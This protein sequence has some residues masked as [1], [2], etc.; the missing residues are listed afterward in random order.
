M[1]GYGLFKILVNNYVFLLFRK[2]GAVCS[3]IDARDSS[4]KAPS[5]HQIPFK[6]VLW[7]R[8]CCGWHRG[9]IS[10][11]GLINYC[12]KRNKAYQLADFITI[13]AVSLTIWPYPA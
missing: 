10:L 4:A 7:A 12:C 8:S 11:T 9:L 2:S 3:E 6:V 13:S 5:S 1:Q